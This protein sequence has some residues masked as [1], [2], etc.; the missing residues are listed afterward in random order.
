M[1]MG[2]YIS[3]SG[4]VTFKN[5]RDLQAVAR[6]VPLERM[7][8]ETDAPYLAPVPHRGRR[9]E[10]SFVPHVAVKVAELHGVTPIES[11][12][13]RQRIS[14]VFSRHCSFIFSFDCLRA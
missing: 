4:I 8:I 12:G 5:A 11:Q 14:S 7:L 9:N 2:F 10:P 13:R 3:F 1:A 6:A